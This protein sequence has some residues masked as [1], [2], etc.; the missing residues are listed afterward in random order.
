MVVLMFWGEYPKGIPF[1]FIY[2]EEKGNLI[3][4]MA[5]GRWT[6]QIFL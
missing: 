6:L 5:K 3:I 4:G 2:K 1:P